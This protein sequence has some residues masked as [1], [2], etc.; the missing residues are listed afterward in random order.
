VATG[1]P[2]ASK[3]E[4]SRKKDVVMDFRIAKQKRIGRELR[5]AAVAAWDGGEDYG[6]DYV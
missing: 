2:D 6:D 3:A 5:L 4:E 1:F